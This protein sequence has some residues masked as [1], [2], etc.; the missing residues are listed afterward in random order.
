MLALSPTI[1]S[2]KHI[3]NYLPIAAGFKA[4]ST[5]P[6]TPICSCLSRRPI[7]SV[8]M[9]PGQSIEGRPEPEMVQPTPEQLKLHYDL[10]KDYDKAISAINRAPPTS[11]LRK[12]DIG[13]CHKDYHSTLT[14]PDGSRLVT[15]VTSSAVILDARRKSVCATSMTKKVTMLPPQRRQI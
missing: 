7:C 1:Q 13:R 14:L 11:W 8:K 9:L 4:K 15:K 10:I 6:T 2:V 3:Y 5:F 12:V